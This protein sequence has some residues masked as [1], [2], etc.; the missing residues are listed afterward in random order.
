[1]FTDFTQNLQIKN[2][3][4]GVQNSATLTLPQ[5]YSVKNITRNL[6]QS[7]CQG[8]RRQLQQKTQ[9]MR[10]GERNQAGTADEFVIYDASLQSHCDI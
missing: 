9:H 3:N 7:Q 6:T 2:K 5:I 4:Q 1:M 8:S 10:E